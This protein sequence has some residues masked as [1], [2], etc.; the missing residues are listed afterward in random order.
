MGNKTCSGPS[1]PMGQGRCTGKPAA[2]PQ[3]VLVRASHPGELT[4]PP[5]S[6]RDYKDNAM[7][8]QLIQ[9]KLD[10]YKADDPTMGE[11]SRDGAGSPGGGYSGDAS[12][13]KSCSSSA[14]QQLQTP[15]GDPEVARLLLTTCGAGGAPSPTADGSPRLCRVRTRLAPSSSSWTAALTLLPRCCTS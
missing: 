6:S 9:D 14:T 13:L 5:A 4:S 1:S 2:P 7:L 11:V 8:A 10:A 12:L 15:N 3:P